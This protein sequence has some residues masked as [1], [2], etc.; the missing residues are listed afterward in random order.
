MRRTLLFPCAFLL[1]QGSMAQDYPM[2]DLTM[3]DNGKGQ[4]ELRIRT[5]GYFDGCPSAFTFTLR[6]P[7]S[8]GVALDTAVRCYPF[9]DVVPVS[10]VAPVVNG[11]YMYRTF[12]GFSVSMLY[13]YG[14]AFETGHEYP[15][16]TADILVP[17]TVVELVDDA[18]TIANNRSFYVSLGGAERTGDYFE[19]PEPDVSIHTQDQGTGYLDVILTPADDFFGWVTDIDFTVRWPAGSG[20]SLGT[21]L[22]NEEVA[23]YMPIEK[24][25]GEVTAGGFTYQKFHGE[26]VKSIANSD[27]AWHAGQ[28]VTALS[29]P[30]F[31]IS[32]GITVIN[33]E[34]TAAN[35]GNYLIELNG[36]GHEGLI[37]G[38]AMGMTTI[39]EEGLGATVLSVANGFNLSVDLPNTVQTATFSLYNAAGQAMW[40]T[41]REGAHGRM[42]VLAET[43]PISDGLYILS[44]RHGERSLTKRVVR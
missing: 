14:L 27:D 29:V 34:W 15:I 43:G 28:D 39:A 30:I 24:V 9:Q 23:E 2:V 40:S 35:D 33:D 36:H 4:V 12:N 7:A 38:I 18:W 11:E 3:S 19:S 1:V 10:A 8:A 17:G 20:V 13:D 31:G 22:Q 26:G 44:V 16:C 32:Q 25:G 42:N 21:V 6:W 41:T 37:E 5:D